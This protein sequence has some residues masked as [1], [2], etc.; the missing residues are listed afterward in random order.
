MLATAKI[1]VACSGGLDSM[2]LS[3][4]CHRLG[5]DHGIAH[6]NFGLRGE[7]SDGDEA[8]VRTYA[9]Q[10]DIPFLC[11]HFDTADYAKTHQLSIQMAARQLRYDWFK[12]KAIAHQYEYVLTAHHA[13]DA[14]ET[15][16]INLSRGTGIEGLTGIPEIND[17][18]IRPLLPFSRKVIATFAKEHKITWRE[19][20]SNSSTKYLRNQ[21]RHEV[22][23]ALKK[24]QPQ[25]LQNFE[26]TQHHLQQSNAVITDMVGQLR[27]TAL[28]SV[29]KNTMRLDLKVLAPY[30]QPKDI[31]Y[32]MLK[33]YGFTAW[34]DIEGLLTAQS[35]KQVFS[36]THRILKDRECLFID[37]LSTSTILERT[38][39]IPDGEQ[40]VMLPDGVLKFETV[41]ER[42][43]A[44]ATTIYVDKSELKYPLTVRKKKEGDYLYP[45][46]M[47]GKKKLSKYFKDEKLS[48]IA[49]ENVWLLC[50]R[51]AIVW[52]VAYRADDRFKVTPKTKQILKITFHHEV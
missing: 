38:Y 25:F 34:D 49:K 35:G 23:P 44:N 6:C 46:G 26:T 12:R 42:G 19:D 22:I 41:S 13:D 27:E 8:F 18:Y 4:L 36:K 50:A 33:A 21:I 11:T 14:L 7:E 40:M 39:T 45:I 2:V 1:L 3:S 52:V 47:K 9:Q 17:I 15:F 37:L 24:I 16:I 31:L 20:S 10:L 29:G 28:Q 32:V 48:L 51:D 43:M 5:L 30:T